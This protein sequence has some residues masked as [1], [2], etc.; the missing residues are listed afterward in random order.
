[1]GCE[2]LIGAFLAK[3][4]FPKR[5]QRELS[6]CH[7]ENAGKKGLPHLPSVRLALAL[8]QYARLEI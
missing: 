2:G 6:R 5:A 3:I 7:S 1:M 8:V 4:T